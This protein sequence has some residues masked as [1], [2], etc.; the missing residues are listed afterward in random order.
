MAFLSLSRWGA[1]VRPLH[2]RSDVFKTN[3]VQ[4]WPNRPP[5]PNHLLYLGEVA[6]HRSPRPQR[7]HLLHLLRLQEDR[8]RLR[9]LR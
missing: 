4:H 6:Q 7:V 5:W 8:L 3:N 2:M 1:Q 9:G